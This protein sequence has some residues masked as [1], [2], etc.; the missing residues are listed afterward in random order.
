MARKQYYTPL[1]H[2][3]GEFLRKEHFETDESGL[4]HKRVMLEI[5]QTSKQ[6]VLI[7]HARKQY[8]VLHNMFTH[9]TLKGFVRTGILPYPK[10]VKPLEELS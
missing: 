8:V 10:S 2:Q 1:A 6:L 3:I 7:N 4:T 9:D 5:K